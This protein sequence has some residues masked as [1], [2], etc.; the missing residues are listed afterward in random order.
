MNAEHQAHPVC[1]YLGG[2]LIYLDCGEPPR[3]YYV[4]KGYIEIEEV[5][6]KE[7]EESYYK[8]QEEPYPERSPILKALVDGANQ[9]LD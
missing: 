1:D 9:T 7:G 6:G 8:M 5:P 4:D 3:D 2:E